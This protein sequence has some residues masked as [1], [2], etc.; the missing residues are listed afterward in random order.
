MSRRDDNDGD[1][2]EVIFDSDR[3]MN[4]AF[5]FAVTAAGVKGDKVITQNGAGEDI[6]WNPIWYV[7]TAIT[8]EGWS[9]EMKIPLTQL[10]FGKAAQQTWGLQLRR[11]F[12]AMKRNPSGSAYRW[13]LPAG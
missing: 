7:K 5:S 13:M 4:S 6:S 8:S 12:S 11:R 10:R 2:V 3:D 1:W 9:A